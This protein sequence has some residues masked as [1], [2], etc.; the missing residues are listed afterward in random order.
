MDHVTE[1]DVEVEFEEE[2][3][4]KKCERI[5]FEQDEDFVKRLTDPKLPKEEEVEKHVLQ[6]HIP[7]RNWCPVCVRARGKEMGHMKS[8]RE[9]GLVEYSWDYCFPGDEFGFK[10]ALLVGKER[11]SKAWMATT[12]PMKGGSGKFPV[13][14][15]LEF[16]LDNGDSEANIILKTD[17]EPAIE[18]LIREV[19][20]M[21]K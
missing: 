14:K 6:G 17:Q 8:E 4:G 7:Y 13:D 12:V 3:E 20:A 16:I 2:I 15:C 21:R 9:R 19:V 5:E 18:A 10:W 11:S 1:D